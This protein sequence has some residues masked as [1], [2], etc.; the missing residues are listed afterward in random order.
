M[1]LVDVNLPPPSAMRGGWAALAAVLSARGWGKNV[2]AEPD[3]WLYHDGGGNW[4]SLRFVERDKI[5]LVGNDHEYSETYFREAAEYFQEEETDLLKGAPDWW[6]SK[7]DPSPFGEWI[8]FVYGWDGCK[9]Q[10]AKYDAEDGFK[11]VGLL[12]SCSL[13]D[14]EHLKGYAADAPGLEGI[15]PSDEALRALVSAD[16]QITP[17]MLQRVIPGWDVEAGVAAARKFLEMPV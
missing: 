6:G 8:G 3:Q 7:L 10:R 14:L 12:E 2:Y 4:A 16:A 5:L 1:S 15:P 11:S 17:E 13:T 9:W